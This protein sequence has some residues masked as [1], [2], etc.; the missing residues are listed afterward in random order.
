ML[1]DLLIIALIIIT[2]N[3]ETEMNGENEINLRV[4]LKSGVNGILSPI[5]ERGSITSDRCI[6][7]YETGISQAQVSRL[8]KGALERI[9]K[10]L[11]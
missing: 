5:P 1:I 2:T 3:I 7:S 11:I 10:Q 6:L 8:E 4:M 9:R